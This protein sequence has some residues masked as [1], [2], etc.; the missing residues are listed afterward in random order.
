M[1]NVV[2][3]MTHNRVQWRK[4]IHIANPKKLD[5]GFFVVVHGVRSYVDLAII[6]IVFSF[7]F[8]N[9]SLIW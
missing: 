6:C 8:M 4:K 2:K 3:E 1:L 5:K 7:N 9:I